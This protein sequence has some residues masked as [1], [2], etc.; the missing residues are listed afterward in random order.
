[1]R[2]FPSTGALAPVSAIDAAMHGEQARGRT[3]ASAPPAAESGDPRTTAAS[4][5]G[6]GC[7]RT[8]MPP[9][10]AASRGK[11]LPSPCRPWRL[12]HARGPGAWPRALGSAWGSPAAMTTI[13]KASSAA[14]F[15]AVSRTA[16]ISA[17]GAPGSPT[18]GFDGALSL[19]VPPCEAA[20][21]S[22][23]RLHMHIPL[24]GLAGRHQFAAR[25]IGCLL[26]QIG[27]PIAGTGGADG[28]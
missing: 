4:P 23:S 1:M 6:S 21:G 24:V 10:A 9:R 27:K 26:V 13:A 18:E 17:A 28:V 5:S 15:I 19:A 11:V 3:T 12:V 8:R 14:G 2:G 25:P 16:A 7:M 22:T 20:F